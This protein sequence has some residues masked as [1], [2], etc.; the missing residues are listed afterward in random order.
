MIT[1]RISCTGALAVALAVALA[2]SPVV[3]HAQGAF[4]RTRPPALTDAAALTVPAVKSVR[5]S[6]GAGLRVVE[7]RELPLVQ[8]VLQIA[9]GGRLD[10]DMPGLAS[11]TANMLDE[12]AGK[13]DANAL[14][15]ELAFLGASLSTSADWDFTTVSLKV[16]RRNLEPALDLMADIVLRP[17]LASTEVRR[18]RDLRLAGLMQQK[19]QARALASLAF[20][21]MMFPAGHPYNNSLA[22]DSAATAQL[23]SATVRQFYNGSFRPARASFTVVGDLSAADARQLLDAR[24]AR[25]TAN[26]AERTP[27][28][29]LVQP[30]RPQGTKVFL[31]DKPS[32]AQSV[33]YIGAPGVERT[34]ADY[35]AIQVM[36]TILG[37]SFSSRLMTNLRET[38]GY[39]YGVNSS[40]AWRPL[41]G[42]FIASS[43]VRTDVT[44]SSLVEFFREIRSI[45]E[46]AVDP[47]ELARA[48]AYL[49]LALPGNLESTSQIA[50]QIT[51]L[52]AYNLPITWLQE[53]ARSIDAVTA[54]DVQRVAQRY[55]PAENALIVIVGD[56]TKVRTKIEALKLGTSSL[57]DVNT[58]TR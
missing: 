26:G 37:G 13:R 54:A 43:D 12:G 56:M 50:G 7:H 47:A 55:I 17:T 49:K 35:A 33:I 58:I 29:V 23:D 19:D 44:D 10:R 48:Q 15:S 16:S 20:N 41:P 38:K 42:P 39:T 14:Q 22:G 51:G 6:N 2:F 57:L 25:W 36:N 8:I 5:L 34:N 45:R 31:V 28:P 46:M 4:D 1:P 32:A 9:G 21:Q 40:F 30:A 11:F 18:Q 24:F 52:S 53:Y 3:S 27:A